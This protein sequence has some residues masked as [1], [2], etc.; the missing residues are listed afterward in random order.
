MKYIDSVDFMHSED[1]RIKKFS[2]MSQG[3]GKSYLTPEMVQYHRENPMERNYVSTGYTNGSKQKMPRYY[4]QKIYSKVDRHAQAQQ[5]QKEK[6]EKESEYKDWFKSEKEQKEYAF[7]KY[8]SSL[9]KNKRD[10][11]ESMDTKNIK[12]K[13]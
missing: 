2:R 1:V 5:I 11:T 10:G 9:S 4:R 12:N 6:L 8:N 7:D 13:K 3:I